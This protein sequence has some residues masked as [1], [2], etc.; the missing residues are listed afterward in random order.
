MATNPWYSAYPRPRNLLP[1]PVSAR[2]LQHWLWS[3]EHGKRKR[4]VVDLRQA[5]HQVAL[6]ALFY[7]ARAKAALA[8]N[9][10][11]LTGRRYT[12]WLNHRL[13]QPSGPHDFPQHSNHS[14]ARHRSRGAERH[15]LLWFVP[16]KGRCDGDLEA[17]VAPRA[18]LTRGC[19]RR[20]RGNIRLIRATSVGCSSGCST[21]AAG[22]FRD[23]LCEQRD[24]NIKSCVLVGG[25]KGWVRGGDNFVQLMDDYH[26][27]SWRV[28]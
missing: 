6:A 21:I 23:F 14:P 3:E 5:D 25:I 18:L 24:F 9:D 15:L 12:G 8:K 2:E 16:P 17:A 4:I 1:V 13:N 20:Q 26:E 7:L 27:A 22:W 19:R 28:P 10:V 11:R